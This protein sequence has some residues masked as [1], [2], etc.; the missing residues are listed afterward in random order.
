LISEK[1]YNRIV[2]KLAINLDKEEWNDFLNVLNKF[3][4][5]LEIADEDDFFGTEGWKHYIGWD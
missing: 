3:E 1:E 2:G 5:L 4:E